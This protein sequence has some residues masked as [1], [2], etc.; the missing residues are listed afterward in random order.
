MT[1]ALL[2]LAL[3]SAQDGSFRP[4]AEKALKKAV[5]F[6]RTHVATEGGYLYRYSEDLSKREGEGRT[7][8]RTVWVQP[9]GT[10]AVGL[11]YLRAWRSTGDSFYLVDLSPQDLES[12][13]RAELDGLRLPGFKNLIEPGTY[14]SLYYL[15]KMDPTLDCEDPAQADQCF[16]SSSYVYP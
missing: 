2:M 4:E 3:G 1:F 13:A 15:L 8:D 5:T 14:P 16:W 6:F 7:N 10:P 9:P 11:A 12:F